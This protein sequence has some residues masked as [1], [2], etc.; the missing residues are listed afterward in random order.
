MKEDERFGFDLLTELQFK[1]GRLRK[2][3][4]AQE[5]GKIGNLGGVI[6]RAVSTE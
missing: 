6:A 2:G 5:E 4:K 1:R 3:V